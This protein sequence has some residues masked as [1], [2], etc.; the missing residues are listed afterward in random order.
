MGS[1]VQALL[2]GRELVLFVLSKLVVH[3]ACRGDQGQL[4]ACSC[5][6]HRVHSRH[7]ER[8]VDVP[9]STHR[10]EAPVL[11]VGSLS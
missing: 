3:L 5:P 11:T 6:D 4:D 10:P 1:E 9:A 2:V 7:K 8:G